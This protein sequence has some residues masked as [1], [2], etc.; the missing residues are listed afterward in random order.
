MVSLPHSVPHSTPY[1]RPVFASFAAAVVNFF[2]MF[3]ASIR[4]ARA[5]EARRQP[6]AADLLQ[7]GIEGP[8]PR[9]W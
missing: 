7:L 9:S 4:V 6:T 2:E 8:L 5:V 1:S 3:G